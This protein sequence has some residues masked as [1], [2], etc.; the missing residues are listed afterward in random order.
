MF[1]YVFGL[2]LAMEIY[3]IHGPEWLYWSN[4][5]HTLFPFMKFGEVVS[6]K[7]FE[8]ILKHFQL[9][10]NENEEQQVLEFAAAVNDRFQKALAPGS[11]ITLDESM[12]KSFHRNLHGKIKILRKLRPVGNGVKNLA[13]AASQIVLNLELYEGKEPM[14][15]KEFVKSFGATTT[16]TIRLTQPYHDSGRRVIADS[17]FSSVKCASELMKCGL[18]CIILVKTIHKGFP[19][20]LL[21]AKKLECGE[22]VAYSTEKD[23]VKLLACCFRDIKIKDS[24]STCSTS[25]SGKPR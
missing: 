18:Y 23:G 12:I 9:S 17:W 16:T 22:W 2:L 4:S 10:E 24:I 19:R 15:T 5:E 1:L 8:N 3:D 13:D 25:I 7:R 11:F 14:S 21:G 6:I 20:Q